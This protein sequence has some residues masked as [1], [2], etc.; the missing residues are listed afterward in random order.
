MSVTTCQPVARLSRQENPAYL[1]EQLITYL[2]N[3]RSL[4]S[5]IETAVEQ[6]KRRLHRSHL[7][8]FDVFSGS[9]VV[10][11]ALKRHASL[12]VS[13][14]LELYAAIAGRCYLANRSEVDLAAIDEWVERLNAR[15]E[16]DPPQPGFVSEMYAPRDESQIT[17]DDRVFYTRNN[18]LRL[19]HY[20]RYLNEVPAEHRDFLLAP[21]LS[22]ASV[23]ANTAGVFKGFYKDRAT[24]IGQFGGSGR[25][26]LS[27]IR[28][29]IV[30]RPPVLSHFECDWQVLQLDANVAARS[31]GEFDLAYLDPPYNQHPYGSNYFMLNLLARYERPERVS[32][33]SG[34]PV[35]W[36]RS[37]Y[38]VR[39]ESL[40]LMT[41]LVQQ[42][43]TRFLL[44]SFNDEGFIAPADMQAMLE[45]VGRV[46]VIKQ[47]YNAFRGSRSFK[48]RSLHVT[49][50]LFLVEK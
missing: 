46:E 11:R 39:I 36:N 19:D 10:S 22:A 17:R 25:D 50:H 23:H 49:E 43:D 1:T 48:N 20:R 31:A 21:L 9:G 15:L 5:Q 8:C 6:I 13:N 40:R 35:D 33:V 3:K 37:G 4:L 18:A 32:R 41:D 12:L 24:K 47:R 30:L 14:D 7:R 44:I 45:K 29:N 2:G 16:V 27:R 42:I 34:I 26:A 28:G 38:N